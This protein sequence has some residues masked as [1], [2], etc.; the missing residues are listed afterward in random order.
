MKHPFALWSTVRTATCVAVALLIFAGSIA[1]VI[2]VQGPGAAP[3]MSDAGS[4]RHLSEVAAGID[5]ARAPEAEAVVPATSV[6]QPGAGVR[7]ATPA[8]PAAPA[9]RLSQTKPSA[10]PVATT[11]AAGTPAQPSAPVTG[12]PTISCDLMNNTHPI[13]LTKGQVLSVGCKITSN[14]GFSAP[15]TLSCGRSP[16]PFTFDLVP[17]PFPCSFSPAIVTPP[18]DGTVSATFTLYVPPDAIWGSYPYGFKTD[19]GAPMRLE[20]VWPLNLRLK[21]PE[22]S[23][24]CDSPYEMPLTVG[25]PSA[26]I[27]CQVTAQPGFDDTVSVFK[28]PNNEW[29]AAKPPCD[30]QPSVPS[31]TFGP[32]GGTQQL[33]FTITCSA[34]IYDPW[35]LVRFEAATGYAGPQFVD[36]SSAIRAVTPR[37]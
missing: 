27:S 31:L 20:P 19:S 8:K 33:S 26:P 22:L 35:F 15:T 11:N 12:G 10:S 18:V 1:A 13:D 37:S 3:S 28:S 29:R 5:S 30:I 9:R 17:G 16:A 25:Q 24:A 2:V 32:A 14:G 21:Q 6:S 34:E 23:V 4:P 36:V 7:E